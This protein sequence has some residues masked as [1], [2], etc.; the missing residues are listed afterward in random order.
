MH[1]Y[2]LIYTLGNRINEEYAV[3]LKIYKMPEKY[4]RLNFYIIA[5]NPTSISLY[6]IKMRIKLS[7]KKIE[8]LNIAEKRIIRKILILVN[9]YCDNLRKR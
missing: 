8:A 4:N 5:E 1:N 9:H 2:Y 7:V 3:N 6:N